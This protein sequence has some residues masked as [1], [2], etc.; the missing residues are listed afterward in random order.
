MNPRETGRRRDEL[1]LGMVDRF[2]CVSTSQM[3][4]ALFSGKSATQ[5]CQR[6][7]RLLHERGLLNRQRLEPGGPY[8][9]SRGR[10]SQHAHRLAVVDVYL[11]CLRERRK[12]ERIEFVPEF[13]LAGGD[14]ADALIWWQTPNADY[15]AFLEVQR[16]GYAR[17]SKYMRYLLSEQWRQEEWGKAGVFPRVLVAGRSK[18]PPARLT[19]TELGRS[20]REA[21][22]RCQ[23][24]AKLPV[25]ISRQTH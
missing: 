7:L 13:T 4:R 8:V 10:V 9:H 23:P 15:L 17:L 22:V 14:R 11:A 2:G 21:M 1:I 6:R 25:E 19:V 3:C 5:S 24:G 18:K 16:T 12:D 20:V